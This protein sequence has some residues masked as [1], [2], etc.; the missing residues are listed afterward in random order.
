MVNKAVEPPGWAIPGWE[1]LT[2]LAQTMGK[3]GYKYT[4]TSQIRREISQLSDN[5]SAFKRVTR[6]ASP[7]VV[8]GKMK[9]PKHK[10]APTE[11]ENWRLY[12]Y[13]DENTYQGFPLMTWVGG[14]QML[15]NDQCVDIHPDD[16][17][18]V[19]VSEDDLILITSA[20]SSNNHTFR[21][22]RSVRLS[23]T[24]PRGTLSILLP[25]PG[26]S[27]T[28]KVSYSDGLPI[29]VSVRKKNV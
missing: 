2:R 22:E 8:E 29:Y 5:L 26:I 18:N 25:S 27:D 9:I 28:P 10:A 15:F 20:Q 17:R 7:L 3:S 6:K 24:Q 4:K 1:I 12:S 11:N 16:A 14:M 19:G 21:L 13:P 23:E